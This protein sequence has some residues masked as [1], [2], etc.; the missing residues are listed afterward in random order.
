MGA[1]AKHEAA[2]VCCGPGA[3]HRALEALLHDARQ[4]PAVVDMGMGQQHAVDFCRW[5]GERLPS[6]AAVF[7]SSP[8]TGR[9]R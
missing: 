7:P 8:E 2:D 9:S 6:C 4:I 3:V 5:D 1:V